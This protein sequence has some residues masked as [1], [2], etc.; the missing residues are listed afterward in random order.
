MSKLRP[1]MIKNRHFESVPFT[2]T[3]FDLMDFGQKDSNGKR[4][5]LTCCDS[6]T[7]Y[8]D[9]FPLGTKTDA[10]VSKNILQLILRHGITNNVFTDNGSEF[11]YLV[12]KR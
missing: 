6:L 4:Y 5:L 10:V 12:L 9:G 8:L 1:S 3:F 11:G 7:S 2:K